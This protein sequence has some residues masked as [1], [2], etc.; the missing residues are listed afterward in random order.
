[1]ISGFF[2]VKSS[3]NVEDSTDTLGEETRVFLFRKIKSILPYWMI[4]G[5]LCLGIRLAMV[6]TIAL[7]IKQIL[8]SFW[9]FLFLQKT[10]LAVYGLINVGWYVSSMLLCMIFLYPICVRKRDIYVN[11]LCPIVAIHVYSYYSRTFGC[12]SVGTNWFGAV[13]SG[14][15][16]VLG[17]LCTG[18][19]LRS[20]PI[21]RKEKRLLYTKNSFYD[22]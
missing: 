4:S 8:F 12:V 1:M 13:N 18:G 22:C 17:G 10:G 6:D 20:E 19:N 21:I 2:M 16:R 14:T 5:I 7:G 15:I 11:L 3:E 9:S